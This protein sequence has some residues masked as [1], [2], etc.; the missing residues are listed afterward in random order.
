MTT[1]TRSQSIIN[2]I[3]DNPAA[4]IQEL[5][6]ISLLATA[7]VQELFEE[8]RVIRETLPLDAELAELMHQDLYQELLCITL[9]KSWKDGQQGSIKMAP[10]PTSYATYQNIVRMDRYL[11]QQYKMT[12][13]TNS[14]SSPLPKPQPAATTSF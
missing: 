13:D 7:G 1:P 5:S 2:Q 9:P 8:M 6:N 12:Q 4:A 10:V 14:R 3:L 11:T